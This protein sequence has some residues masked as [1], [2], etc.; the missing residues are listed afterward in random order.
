MSL[1]SRFIK[2]PKKKLT[3]LIRGDATI[4]IEEL[5]ELDE[6]QCNPDIVEKALKLLQDPKHTQDGYHILAFLAAEGNSDAQFY[7]GD[8][9][10]SVLNHPEQA[11]TWYQCAADQGHPQ[12]QRNYANFL[13]IGKGLKANPKLAVTYY[14]KAAVT[15]IPEAQFVMGEFYRG[16]HNVTK[17][18][19]AALNWYKKAAGQGYKPAEERIRQLWPNGVFQEPQTPTALR[20]ENLRKESHYNAGECSELLSIILEV[21]KRQKYIPTDGVPFVAE[22]RPYQSKV[23]EH[24]C[25]WVNNDMKTKGLDHDQM[26]ALFRYTFFQGFFDMKRWHD[27]SDG[28][29]GHIFLTDPFGEFPLLHSL[30]TELRGVIDGIAAPQLFCDLMLVWWTKNEHDLRQKGVDIWVPFTLALSTTYGIAVSIALKM[31]GYRK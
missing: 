22:L 6:I 14:K 3:D 8:F 31:F 19:E 21:A 23:V 12:A 27:S 15:G 7:M 18:I 26:L 28:R 9:C 25:S 10:E 2:T 5:L 4:T 13:M 30:P 29:I 17:D 24:V 1:F 20:E 16:G 11:A